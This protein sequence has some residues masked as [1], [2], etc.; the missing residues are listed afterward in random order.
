MKTYSM[1]LRERVL[2][3]SKSM[4]T[5]EVANKYRVSQAWVRRLKQRFRET[6]ELGPKKKRRGPVPA[7]VVYADR[8]RDAVQ[9]AKD[10]TLDELCARFGLP[11]S[12]ATL[13]RALLVLGL[14]RKKSRSEP[15]SKT[16]PM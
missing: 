7:A 13:G 15:A 11:M 1:D 16:D 10:A 4:G 6:G 5:L 3:D 2:E 12:R 14:T 9:E 8:I